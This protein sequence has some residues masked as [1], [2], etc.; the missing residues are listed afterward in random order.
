MIYKLRLT[1]GMRL[2]SYSMV[3]FPYVFEDKLQTNDKSTI[4]L[5]TEQELT[6]D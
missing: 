5:L 4:I 3:T 6:P 2:E 1:H